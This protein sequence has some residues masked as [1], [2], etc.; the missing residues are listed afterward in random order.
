[1]K[2]EII[3]ICILMIAL[4]GCKQKEPEVITPNETTETNYTQPIE[5]IDK[6]GTNI[7]FTRESIVATTDDYNL[8]LNTDSVADTIYLLNGNDLKLDGVL[9]SSLFKEVDMIKLIAIRENATIYNNGLVNNFGVYNNSQTIIKTTKISDKITLIPTYS[10]GFTDDSSILVEVKDDNSF[11]YF[12]DVN[13]NYITVKGIK[14]DV[15]KLDECVSDIDFFVL[16]NPKI[17]VYNN[18]CTNMT[19]LLDILNIKH[20]SSPVNINLNRLE[21]W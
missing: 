14:A 19:A 3:I 5:V 9:I 18:Y 12:S 1:M 20:Y 10:K 13:L 6:S 21:K 4:V 16:V 11:V 8:L 17:V 15:I 7:M 2:I